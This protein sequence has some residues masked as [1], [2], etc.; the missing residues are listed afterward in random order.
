ML[1]EFDYGGCMAKDPNRHWGT[2]AEL[3]HI[4][5]LAKD[6]WFSSE[7]GPAKIPIKKLLE[8]YIKGAFDRRDN[9]LSPEID[10]TAC[11]KRARE[12]MQHK[13]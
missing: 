13:Q 9:G 10:W 4:E 3:E 8:N 7:H 2:T 5:G 1:Q 12:L 11:I 6:K